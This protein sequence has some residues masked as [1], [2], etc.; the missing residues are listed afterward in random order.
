MSGFGL[1]FKKGDL[2]AV[3]FV[4]A[5]IAV[6]FIVFSARGKGG[7]AVVTLDGQEIARLPLSEDTERRPA[8]TA[9]A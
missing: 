1:K 4:I 5:L 3:L 6:L 7:Y 9:T 8:R 2:W